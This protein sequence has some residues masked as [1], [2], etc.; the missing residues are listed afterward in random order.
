MCKS[1]GW[2][3]LFL[4]AATGCES[5]QVVSDQEQREIDND[6]RPRVRRVSGSSL[7]RV[8]LLRPT[9]SGS[10]NARELFSSWRRQFEDDRGFD[11]VPQGDVD[12]V[13][14]AAGGEFYRLGSAKRVSLIVRKTTMVA[15]VESNITGERQSYAVEGTDI[16]RIDDLLAQLASDVKRALRG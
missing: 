12:S 3:A 15:T 4:I 6:F 5:I 9:L 10:L 8:A 13:D 7:V 1:A 14:E 16:K 2:L 11:V